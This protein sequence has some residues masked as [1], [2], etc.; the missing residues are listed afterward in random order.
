MSSSAV[1]TRQRRWKSPSLLTNVLAFLVCAAGAS[2]GVTLTTFMAISETGAPAVSSAGESRIYADSTSHNVKVSSNGGTYSPLVTDVTSQFYL[3][4]TSGLLFDWRM[5]E[6]DGSQGSGTTLKDCSG[7][8]NT[9]T[10]H[11]AGASTPTFGLTG[12][13]FVGTNNQYVQLDTSVTSQIKTVIVASTKSS[14]A[15][16]FPMWVGNTSS[17]GWH[18]YQTYD[19]VTNSPTTFK[20]NSY[21][22]KTAEAF[23]NP[24]VVAAVIQ[25]GQNDQVFVSSPTPSEWNETPYVTGSRGDSSAGFATG[26]LQLGGSTGKG[27]YFSGTFYRALAYSTALTATQLRQTYMALKNDMNRRGV[28]LYPRNTATNN[29]LV[30]VGDSITAGGTGGATSWVTLLTTSDT[31]TKVNMGSSG[32]KAVEALTRLQGDIIPLAA[33]YGARNVAVV[34]IG[35]NDI[36]GGIAPAAVQASIMAIARTLVLYGF[37]VL[38]VGQLSRCTGVEANIQALNVLLQNN[39]ET[40]GY[41][42]MLPDP[43]LTATN[44]CAN[45]TYFSDGTHP[46]TTGEQLLANDIGDAVDSMVNAPCISATGACG[47]A[48]HGYFDIAGGGPTTRAVTTTAMDPNATLEVEIQEDITIGA[49]LGVTCDTTT[50]RTYTITV[51][52]APGTVPASAGFT[53]KSSA[54]TAGDPI[55]LRFIVK[56]IR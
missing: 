20:S 23:S 40:G 7:N 21:I 54:A 1:E 56:R 39:A 48:T 5:A 51:K 33:G 45:T 18:L 11:G 30:A 25:S 52:T 49:L 6:C 46:T 43:L 3:P 2:A 28:T 38:V 50:G 37:Q 17:N 44:A 4:V 10:L 12:L 26:T 53:V 22:T 36:N 29:E 15:G 8:G 31:F 35:T 14:Y 47:Y 55:C 32:Q 42:Y 24:G 9:A 34:D 19:E 27:T 41:T 13:T 16:G